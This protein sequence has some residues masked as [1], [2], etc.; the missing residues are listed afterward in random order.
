MV[1]LL[2]Q[3]RE[4]RSN[5]SPQLQL[6]KNVPKRQLKKKMGEV[7]RKTEHSSSSAYRGQT[8]HQEKSFNSMCR[9]DV[10]STCIYRKLSSVPFRNVMSSLWKGHKGA[11]CAHHC[12]Q[13]AM[14]TTRCFPERHRLLHRPHILILCKSLHHNH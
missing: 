8:A 10:S 2:G 12:S 4:A 3:M 1:Q 7:M 9:A 5:P 11:C 14:A 6:Q 13:E